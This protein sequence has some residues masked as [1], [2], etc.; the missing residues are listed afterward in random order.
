MTRAGRFLWLDWAQAGLLKYEG[1][2]AGGLAA[3]EHDG[4]WRVGV[5]HRRSVTAANEGSW[6]VR[7]DLLPL[8]GPA[9]RRARLHWLV[10][11][12]PWEA[13][14]QDGES[15]LQ[16]QTPHGWVS[17]VVQSSPASNCTAALI[18]GGS[19]LFG[20]GPAEPTW[21]WR[22]PAYGRKVAA[23]SFAVTVSGPLPLSFVSVWTLP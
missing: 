9:I 13:A 23:L 21:G 8:A 17:L 20:E 22:A 14:H 4:Y 10:P 3:A 1:D 19:V 15:R 11:D 5:R 18:R 7:D 12:W 6:V 16:L 2:D